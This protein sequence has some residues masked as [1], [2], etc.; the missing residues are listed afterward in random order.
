MIFFPLYF[1]FLSSLI[2]TYLE[3]VLAIR[4]QD[5]YLLEMHWN[6]LVFLIQPTFVLLGTGIYMI[7]THFVVSLAKTI[8]VL[9]G[10]LLLVAG[11]CLVGPVS[12]I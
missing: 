10:A 2:Q 5:H 9:L 11:I 3:P 7:I 4:L 1:V 12:Y 8:T 6:N